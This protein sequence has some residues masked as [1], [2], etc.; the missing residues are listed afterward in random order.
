[1]F[2]VGWLN[3]R[4]KWRIPELLLGVILAAGAVYALELDR[5]LQDQSGEVLRR[6]VNVIGAIPRSL[7]SF[8]PPQGTWL[9]VRQRSGSALAIAVLG[10]LEAMAMAKAIAART[11]QKLDMN[12]QCLSEGLANTV[13][14]FFQCYA[15]SG[16]LTRSAINHQAGGVTQWSAMISAFAVGATVLLFAPL[17]YYIPRAALAGILIVSAFRMVDAHK[18][19]FH[20]RVTKMDAVIVLATAVAAV[21]VSVE[22]CILIG[23][24]V[25]FLIYLPR[26]ARVDVTELVLSPQGLIRERSSGDWQCDRLRIYSIEGELFF[27]SSTELRDELGKIEERL[28]GTRVVLLRLKYAR[29]LDGV[30]LDVLEDFVERMTAR[31]VTVILCGVREDMVKVLQNVGLVERLG[32]Q[33]LFPEGAAIWSSTLQAVER[34]YEILGDD[35]CPTCP[36]SRGNGAPMKDWNYVI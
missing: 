10:V 30:G 14:S 22:F 1:V 9:Q 7:P 5:P 15:G 11:G 24:F 4:F 20:M 12:Q 34:A 26:A 35:R 27:G 6:G 31:E 33:R 17:A 29:N 25:S 2:A 32:P 13:G 3:R 8:Q 23:T 19:A 28:N 36:V 21:A 18:L 16:S